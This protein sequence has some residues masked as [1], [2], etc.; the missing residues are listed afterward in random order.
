MTA[1]QTNREKTYFLV[2]K[3][4]LDTLA[5]FCIWDKKNFPSAVPKHK[6]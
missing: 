1:V 5:K 3:I 2:D 4:V 6:E